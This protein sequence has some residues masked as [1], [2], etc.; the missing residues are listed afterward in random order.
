MDGFRVTYTVECAESAAL[1]SPNRRETLERGLAVLA[2]NPY[3]PATAPIGTHEDNRK[4]QVAPG[5]LIE[6]V[7][8]HA[9]MVVVVL[10]VF[11]ESLYLLADVP[12]QVERGMEGDAALGGGG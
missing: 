6:Y 8:A 7:V 11:D 12:G 9:V 3:H 4:A 5:V 1:L 2:R 10:T